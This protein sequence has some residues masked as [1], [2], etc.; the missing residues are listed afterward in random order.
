VREALARVGAE[1]AGGTSAEFGELITSQVAY[2]DKI[3][4]DSG[5]K[6]QQ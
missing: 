3:V 2:W 4:K 6:M 5:I 1:S